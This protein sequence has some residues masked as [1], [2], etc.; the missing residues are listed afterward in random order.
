VDAAQN[1]VLGYVSFNVLAAGVLLLARRVPLALL[2]SV[3]FGIV[4]SDA[5]FILNIGILVAGTEALYWT[6]LALFVRAAFTVPRLGSRALLTLTLIGAYGFSCFI[7]KNLENNLDPFARLFMNPSLAQ[8]I[9]LRFPLLLMV[10][11]CCLGVQLLL[12]RN[13]T[14]TGPIVD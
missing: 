9:L 2:Q 7:E 12:Q 1:M 3:V 14:D 8:P 11:A 13:K 5:V 10:A 6:F 4:L